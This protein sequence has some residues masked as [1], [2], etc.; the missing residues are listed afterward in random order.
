MKFNDVD[1]AKNNGITIITF[2]WEDILLKIK[3]LNRPEF[4]YV[5]MMQAL[6]TSDPK[7][8]FIWK[9]FPLKM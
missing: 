5:R 1:T 9:D 8:R 2:V 3:N 7:I 4:A 6:E